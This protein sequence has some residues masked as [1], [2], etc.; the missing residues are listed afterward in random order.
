MHISR[1]AVPRALSIARAKDAGFYIETPLST[2]LVTTTQ[3][4]GMDVKYK[5]ENCQPSGSFK[6]RGIGNMI[7]SLIDN[8]KVNRLISSSGGNAGMAVAT[9]G[10]K[11]G[12]PVDIYVPK[13]TLPMMIE[14]LK[15]KK[16][17]VFVFGENWNEADT[18]ARAALSANP[19]AGYIPPYDDPLIWEGHSSI[20]DELKASLGD[21]GR[22][23][24]IVLSVGG[25]G[26]LAGIQ[27]GL[28][29]VGWN[30]VRVI[31]VE[32]EG[33]ASFAAAKTAGEIVK[34]DKISTIASSLGALS[35]TTAV[36]DKNSNA[37]SLT[38]SLIVSDAEAVDACLKFADE[39]RALVE[40]AC[41]AALAAVYST[42]HRET[43]LADKEGIYR[44]VVIVC[45]GSVVSL[46]LLQSW[47]EKFRSN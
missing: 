43:L 7:Q 28:D 35:V 6:S 18:F 42:R 34:L 11:V 25:G 33:A 17:N 30:D 4:G 46:D 12:L 26:L 45:G 14:K 39:Q 1:G 22:P 10:E 21:F 20:V 9:T 13:T 5:M 32:T 23:H 44:V 29:R 37:V 31:A 41:G 16:A 3:Y 36:L 24:A 2:S 15:Q 47:K 40:P 19:L 8:S 27:R 38:E